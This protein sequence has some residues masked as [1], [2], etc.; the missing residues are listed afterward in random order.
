MPDWFVSL[1]L[2]CLGVSVIIGS[3]LIVVYTALLVVYALL[4]ILCRRDRRD[5]WKRKH[6]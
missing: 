4:P 3:V 1:V 5:E 6:L 2:I